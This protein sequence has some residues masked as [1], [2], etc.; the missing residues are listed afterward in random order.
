[1]RF[2]EQNGLITIEK[3][4]VAIPR[5]SDKINKANIHTY[6]LYVPVCIFGLFILL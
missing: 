5:L 2:D 3:Q 1:V 6:T 4:H